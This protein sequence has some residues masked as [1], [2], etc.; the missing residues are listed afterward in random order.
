MGGEIVL[1]SERT[2]AAPS[3]R[4]ADPLR[5]RDRPCRDGA[6]CMPYMYVGWERMVMMQHQRSSRLMD[7]SRGGALDPVPARAHVQASRC[8]RGDAV[9]VRGP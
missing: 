1:L 5:Y 3:E 8:T 2:D 6:Q 4:C 7:R 9:G